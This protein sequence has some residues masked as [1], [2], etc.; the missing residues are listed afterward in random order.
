MIQVSTTISVREYEPQHQP[1][2]EKF[3]R[4]WIERYFWME[5]IDFEVLQHPDKHILAHGGAILMAYAGEDVAG[6]VALK[7]VSPGIYEF[8]KMAV[9]EK[10]QGLKIGRLLA[11]TAIVKAKSMGA[12]KIILYSH[13]SLATA[14][15]LYRKLG[16]I[17]VPVDGPYKRSDIKME[18]TA[19]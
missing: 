9:D 17:E 11:E 5:P 1:W 3:N 7:Y 14:I 6:T 2:F 13:T 16:F 8:T 18:L 15:G 10:F 19:L 4:A 12:H